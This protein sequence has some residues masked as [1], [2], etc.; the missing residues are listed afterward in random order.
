MKP[1]SAPVVYTFLIR[2]VLLFAVWWL[3][4]LGDTSGLAMGAVVAGLVALV[5]LRLFLPAPYR[6]HPVALLQFSGYFLTRS[7]VAGLDVA[8]RLLSPSLPV[9]PG[10]VK[11]TSRLPGEGP[12]ALL[13]NTL[14]LMPGTLCVNLEDN[15]LRVHCLNI[16]APIEQDIR[17]TEQRIAEVFGLQL[18]RDE[19]AV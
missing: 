2:F 5:S 6:L 15:Q 10:E 18:D 19:S 3:L 7:V 8:L 16:E 11:V 4:T 1:V 14:S 12:R 13:A 17:N 9:N